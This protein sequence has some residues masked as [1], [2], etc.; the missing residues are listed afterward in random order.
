MH[1]AEIFTYLE[2]EWSLGEKRIAEAK[3]VSHD[4]YASYEVDVAEFTQEE[5][6]EGN[7]NS[8]DALDLF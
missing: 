8:D 3:R 7:T 6:N 1:P 2:L 4:V 5:D